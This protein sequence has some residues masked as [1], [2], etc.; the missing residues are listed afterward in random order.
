[1]EEKKRLWVQTKM[2]PCFY[3]MVSCKV[4]SVC[5]VGINLNGLPFSFRCRW[6]GARRTRG[7]PGADGGAGWTRSGQTEGGCRGF[8]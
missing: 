8:R 4:A 1:M 3:K 2:D 5:K 7:S 6:P